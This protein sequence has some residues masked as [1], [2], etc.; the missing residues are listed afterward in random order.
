MCNNFELKNLEEYHDL[1][2]QSDTLLLADALENFRNMRLKINELDY[3]SFPAA[4]RWTW[5]GF[6]KQT[7]VKLDLLTDIDKLIMVEKSIRGGID[8]AIHQHIKANNKY[9]EILW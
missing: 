3:A 6:L 1:Y 5:E 4:P 8:L 7:K 2:D 9:I